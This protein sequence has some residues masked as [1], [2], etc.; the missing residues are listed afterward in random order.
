[1]RTLLIYN[2]RLETFLAKIEDALYRLSL[3]IL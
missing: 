2:S 1:M 3:K